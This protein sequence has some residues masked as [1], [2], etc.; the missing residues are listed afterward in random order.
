MTCQARSS[1]V[2]DEVLWGHRF[3]SVL[4]LEKDFY[5]VN[6]VLVV[7]IFNICIG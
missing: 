2:E 1:Y 5:K 4:H 7:H 3:I 6:C